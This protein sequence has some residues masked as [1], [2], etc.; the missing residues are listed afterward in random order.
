[1]TSASDIH[2]RLSRMPHILTIVSP[3]DLTTPQIAAF[4]Q[5]GGHSVYELGPDAADIRFAEAPV[6]DE[7]AQL[8]TEH[9]FDFAIHDEADVREKKF[10]QADM[11]ST[12]IEQ[13]CLDELADLA[14]VGAEVAAVTER[15]MRGELDFEAALNER[16]A[17]LEGLPVTACEDVLRE[18]LTL[19]PGAR[20]LIASMNARGAKTVLV[21]GGFEIFVRE[22]ARLCG[23]QAHHA[24]LLEISGDRLTGRVL[25]PILGREAKA[26]ILN[27]EVTALGLSHAETMALGDGANDLG[28]IE[29]S[30]LG[31]AYKAKPVT[32]A[33]A[34]AAIN[35]TGLH[36]ALYFQG[37]RAEE[38]I[39]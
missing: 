30:G 24:N 34:D 11:D 35:H 19:S 2:N 31:I 7:V 38:F 9:G 18:R 25:R 16:V 8:A 3:R 10:L 26:D 15:A 27:R 20:T 5:L 12:I 6:W 23:F 22:I 13:E 29:A 1:M 17:R 39:A 32:A 33:A 28:M 21:S 4:T 37:I 14:G 36:A